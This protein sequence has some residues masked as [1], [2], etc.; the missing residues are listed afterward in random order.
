[1]QKPTESWRLAALDRKLLQKCQHNVGLYWLLGHILVF[2]YLYIYTVRRQQL[3]DS[4]SI[5]CVGK[6]LF[7]RLHPHEGG[8]SNQL[9]NIGHNFNN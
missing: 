6:F 2:L 4:N 9:H 8:T 1:M 3:F 7:T 5:F